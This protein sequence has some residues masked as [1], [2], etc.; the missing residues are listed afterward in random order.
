MGGR[1]LIHWSLHLLLARV[2]TGRKLELDQSWD[3]NPDVH[4]SPGLFL[5]LRHST[6]PRFGDNAVDPYP[7]L[8]IHQL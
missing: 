8:A 2:H 7:N 4:L 5:C 6:K 1:D 3:R